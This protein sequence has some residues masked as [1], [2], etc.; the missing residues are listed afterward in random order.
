MPAP[1]SLSLKNSSPVNTGRYLDVKTTLC[2]PKTHKTQDVNWTSIPRFFRTL[3][4]SNGP[5]NNVVFLKIPCYHRTLFGRRFNVFQTLY[6]CH[7]W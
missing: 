6:G 7:R 4:T 2:I 3:W 5:Q 1:V